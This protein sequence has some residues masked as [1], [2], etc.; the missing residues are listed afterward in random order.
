MDKEEFK[1]LQRAEEKSFKRKSKQALY[2]W[3]IQFEEYINDKLNKMY[4]K[5]F[6]EELAYSI[7]CFVIAI[8]F[9][10]HFGETTKFGPKRLN[11][12]MEDINA[13]VDMFRTGEYSPDEYKKMLKNDGIIIKTNNENGEKDENT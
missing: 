2:D 5:K 1:R 10:L 11:K 12:I 4:E 9:T 3:G 8:M 13:T 6:K 7:D